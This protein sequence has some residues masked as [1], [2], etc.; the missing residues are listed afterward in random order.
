METVSL[1]VTIIGFLIIG[2]YQ[3]YSIKSL[4]EQIKA[5]KD[6]VEIFQPDKIQEFVKMRETTFEDKK[7]KEIAKIK[8]EMEI[9]SKNN[10]NSTKQHL[11]EFIS[12]LKFILR[13]S[14]FV[15]PNIRQSI[16][17]GM[18]DS[19]TIK[20]VFK[21]IKDA[22]YYEFEILDRINKKKLSDK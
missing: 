2:C 21:D 7:D 10:A 17:E 11:N 13:L 14:Y 12:A 6:I 9:K 4:K 16:L 20:D 1:I 3:R 18:T 8:S 5:Q 19:E 22:P 15:H